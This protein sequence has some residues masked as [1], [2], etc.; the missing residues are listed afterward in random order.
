MKIYAVG[1]LLTVLLVN[2]VFS[3]EFTF[4]ISVTD[5]TFHKFIYIGIHPDGTAGYDPGLDTLAPPPPP[6]GSFDTRLE[7]LNEDYYTDIRDNTLNQKEF[8]LLYAPSTGGSIII[9]WDSS[10]VKQ[11][12][13]FVIKDNLTGELFSLDMSTTDSLIINQYPVL[14]NG[15]KI[16]V[17]PNNSSSVEDNGD[18]STKDMSPYIFLNYP[19]PFNPSTIIRYFVPHSSRVVIKVFNILGNEIETLVN[20]GKSAGT[21]EIEFNSHLGSDRNLPSGL[22]FYRLQ[23]GSFIESKKMI[24]LR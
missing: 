22:Y 6:S 12:G 8:Y 16:F 19:N 18:C 9:Y 4:P 14:Q 13:E 3:Q 11:F 17:T 21:Y 1:I 7:Y 10:L 15:L 23:T 2:N 5:G 24:L 20:E